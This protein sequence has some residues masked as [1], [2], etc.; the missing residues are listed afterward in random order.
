MK[1]SVSRHLNCIEVE[2]EFDVSVESLASMEDF[3]EFCKKLV[4]KI[5]AFFGSHEAMFKYI[6]ANMKLFDDL[7]SSAIV[8]TVLAKDLS[9][10]GNAI[11]TINEGLER[12]RLGEKIEL[13]EFCGQ[14]LEDVGIEYD[15][16]RMSIVKF[17]SGNWG[18]GKDKTGLDH[19]ME[20]RKSISEF[21]WTE[22]AK[23]YAERFLKLATTT[24]KAKLIAAS[25][26]HYVDV[27]NAMAKGLSR[28]QAIYDKELAVDQISQLNTI[29]NM[30]LKFYF[31]QLCEIM[32]ASNVQ[33]IGVPPKAVKLPETYV[34]K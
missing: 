6:S 32:K 4:F 14:A 29:R 30:L 19:P 8:K 1:Y 33:P 16:G 34:A 13:R 5:G 7:N 28:N 23:H 12:L 9:A 3:T 22:G 27:K 20:Y 24:S 21:G 15:R 17:K 10:V 26:R 11:E 2:R 25:N 31:R 18:D